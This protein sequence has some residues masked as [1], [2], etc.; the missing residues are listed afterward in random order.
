MI[1]VVNVGDESVKIL[2]KVLFVE[3]YFNFVIRVI[4]INVVYKIGKYVEI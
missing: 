4:V 2:V 1:S 3:M